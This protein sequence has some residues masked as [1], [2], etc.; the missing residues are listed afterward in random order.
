M[1][2]QSSKTDNETNTFQPEPQTQ[3]FVKKRSKTISFIKLF[4]VF[5]FGLM[6]GVVITLTR[7]KSDKPL[8]P[9]IKVEEENQTQETELSQ[10]N[11]DVEL[12]LSGLSVQLNDALTNKG[13]NFFDPS[14]LAAVPYIIKCVQNPKN[15]SITPKEPW[16][17]NILN[18]YPNST[19]TSICKNSTT[20]EYL[21]VS[22]VKEEYKKFITPKLSL[23]EDGETKSEIE[24]TEQLWTHGHCGDIK[25]WYQD[26]KVELICTPHIYVAD[27]DNK[28]LSILEYNIL[29]GSGTGWTLNSNL[30]KY[31]AR[32]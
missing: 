8:E 26:N 19:V 12:L 27:L 2:N 15:E 22:F 14:S 1:N 3:N 29:V 24:L 10:S 21:I 13:N 17:R 4:T 6:L 32:Y 16:A 18:Y 30:N 28:K 9:T 23:F 20:N 25:N 11:K 31:E 7:T 5:L